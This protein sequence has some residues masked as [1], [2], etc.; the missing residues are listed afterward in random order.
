MGKYRVEIASKPSF[1]SVKE[2]K[3]FTRSEAPNKKL[4]NIAFQDDIECVCCTQKAP[5]QAAAMLK[6]EE[7]T[8]T[9]LEFQQKDGE[10]VWLCADCFHS[11]VRP[12]YVHFG[13]VKWNKEGKR[14]QKRAEKKAGHPWG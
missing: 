4:Y 2:C 3:E 10:V 7:R 1:E 13:N 8:P 14:I 6:V 9:T 12:K 5:V 11:G